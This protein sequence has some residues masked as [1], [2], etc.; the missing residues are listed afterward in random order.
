MELEPNSRVLFVGTER[1]I[2]ATKVPEAGFDLK[3]IDVAG[4]KRVGGMQR[5]KG[6]AKLP[7]SF[8]SSTSILR[9][10]RADAEI[11]VGGYASGPVVMAAKLLGIPTAV[12]EQNSV[13]GITN[14]IL[15]RVVR[16]V[17]GTF[18][19]SA[20][21]FPA[22]KFSL[23]GNPV[24]RA[25]VHAAAEEA[26]EVRRG[27]VFTFGGSQGARPLNET[28]PEALGILK[29]R[30]VE[31]HAVHQA[32]NA[33]VEQVRERYAS[34]SVAAEV[35]PFIDDMVA[36]YRAAD[37][38]ICRAGA[39]SCSEIAA[40]GVPAIFIPFPQ[41]ADDHQT[42]NAKDMTDRG[43]G[44][45]LPQSEMTATRLADE[46]MALLQNRGSRDSMAKAAGA[47]GRLDA[48]DVVATSAMDGFARTAATES[49]P[50]IPLTPSEAT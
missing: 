37:V 3:L 31:V 12:C 50:A 48:A 1:G 19:S 29:T 16:R 2:E 49:P 44:V 28:V 24:R 20:S 36:A 18:P 30:G 25:F 8:V 41:A 10:F 13:P 15:G 23:V 47:L 43:A 38:V 32:G 21:F 7:M 39:T 5:I 46:V 11:G 34:A 33:E 9:E 42:T 40:L 14:R 4:L 6:F 22:S 45:L 35:T 26:P 27:R 17:F